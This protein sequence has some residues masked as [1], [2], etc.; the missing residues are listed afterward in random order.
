MQPNIMLIKEGTLDYRFDLAQELKKVG[1]DHVPL[2]YDT[3]YRAYRMRIPVE[4]VVK[5]IIME[6]KR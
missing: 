4:R 3:I 6:G 2:S 1:I 5:N